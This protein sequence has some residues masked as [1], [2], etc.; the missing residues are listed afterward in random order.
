ML[1]ASGTVFFKRVTVFPEAWRGSITYLGDDFAYGGYVFVAQVGTVGVLREENEKVVV[2]CLVEFVVCGIQ[3]DVV[4]AFFVFGDFSGV[5]QG[6]N[7]DVLLTRNHVLQVYVG[8][9]CF[10]CAVNVF[11]GVVF[12]DHDI[13][14]FRK[15]VP[16]QRHGEQFFF[17]KET[18][19]SFPAFGIPVIMFVHGLAVDRVVRHNVESVSPL[20]PV[21][22]FFDMFC[23]HL[24][25]SDRM[26]LS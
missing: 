26:P 16:A 8:A 19:N 9:V 4:A 1:F 3:V 2:V 10:E 7:C 18:E 21:E 14:V 13:N 24:L 6:S 11:L 23:F 17:F 22:P 15:I 20:S 12:L 25:Y 5:G